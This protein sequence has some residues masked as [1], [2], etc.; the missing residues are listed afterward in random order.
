MILLF[1]IV[2]RMPTI[3]ELIVATPLSLSSPSATGLSAHSPAQRV[4]FHRSGTPQYDP[5]SSLIRQGD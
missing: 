3:S 1:L 4:I 2:R 5:A